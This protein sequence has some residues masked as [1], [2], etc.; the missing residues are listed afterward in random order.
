MN[1]NLL[2]LLEGSHKWDISNRQRRSRYGSGS[3]CV[4][5]GF[6]V[7]T[8]TTVGIA[9]VAAHESYQVVNA[10]GMLEILTIQRVLLLLETKP[11]EGLQPLDVG[12]NR[13]RV[14]AARNTLKQEKPSSF[15]NESF[16]TRLTH[17]QEGS[18][19]GPAICFGRKPEVGDGHY[20]VHIQA[21]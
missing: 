18:K 17:V 20:I 11:K 10:Q 15:L 2:I 7:A 12:V 3:L 8:M 21:A 4:R 6:S 13:S 19:H 1:Q 5:T 16:C 9:G 14:G